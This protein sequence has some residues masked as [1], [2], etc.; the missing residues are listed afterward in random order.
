MALTD[1]PECEKKI[2][3]KAVSCPNCGYPMAEEKSGRRIETFFLEPLADLAEMAEK[4]IHSL[5]E[6]LE[7][8]GK[9]ERQEGK[10]E[11]DPPGYGDKGPE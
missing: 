7:R 5:R 4:S 2:S 1:C 6:A 8:R 3:D 10:K 11:P 9:G